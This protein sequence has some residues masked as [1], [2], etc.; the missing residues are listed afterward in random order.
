M[1]VHRY[2]SKRSVSSS[3]ARMV[4]ILLSWVAYPG[5]D[6]M[7]GEW[8]PGSQWQLK[9][10]RKLMPWCPTWLSARLMIKT[11]IAEIGPFYGISAWVVRMDE[12]TVR[13]SM[14]VNQRLRW[15]DFKCLTKLRMLCPTG[16]ITDDHFGLWGEGLQSLCHHSVVL[17]RL[18]PSEAL[19]LH[20]QK[21]VRMSHRQ[22]LTSYDIF[23]LFEVRSL[24]FLINSILA[25][26]VRLP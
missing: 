18:T 25:K 8:P 11:Q 12:W 6:M 10:P 5:D 19:L 16:S 9:S 26:T 23:L 7:S 2:Q 22:L 17:H 14:S 21:L 13:L 1:A 3:E 4:R 20:S 15:I 24:R